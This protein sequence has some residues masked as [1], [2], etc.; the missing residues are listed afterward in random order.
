MSRILI[1]IF[2]ISF[3]NSQDSLNIHKGVDD[4]IKNNYLNIRNKLFFVD[5]FKSKDTLFISC[6]QIASIDE[7]KLFV[8]SCEKNVYYYSISSNSILIARSLDQRDSIIFK[9]FAK[10]NIESFDTIKSRFDTNF[11]YSHN[12]KL[13]FSFLKFLPN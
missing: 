3:L 4:Y 1:I 13:R 11:Y 5:L 6:E 8:E 9:Q 2:A 12:H 7:F 10:S